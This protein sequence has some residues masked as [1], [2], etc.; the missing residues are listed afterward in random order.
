VGERELIYSYVSPTLQFP[1]Q[2]FMSWLFSSN[3]CSIWTE[4]NKIVLRGK[5]RPYCIHHNLFLNLASYSYRALLALWWGTTRS[6][7]KKKFLK[8]AI[9]DDVLK[10][11]LLVAW[12]VWSGQMRLCTSIVSLPDLTPAGSSCFTL[13]Y[14]L[15]HDLPFKLTKGCHH[16]S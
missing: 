5:V 2:S 9:R 7:L 8:F 15:G 4:R 10:A 14:N 11:I 1:I 13:K 6:A 3:A 16:H 12:T